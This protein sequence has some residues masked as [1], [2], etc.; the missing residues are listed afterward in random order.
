M[1]IAERLYSML[2][3]TYPARLRADFGI[4][5][6]QLFA[7]QLADARQRHSTGRLYARTL[8]DWLQTV[9]AEHYSEYRRRPA[10]DRTRTPVHRL[11]RR[12]LVFAPNPSTAVL[13]TAGILAWRCFRKLQEKGQA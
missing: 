9:P 2:L 7:D 11:F 5:M 10:A 12:G 13:I 1:G 3:R 6:L 4:E 8:L